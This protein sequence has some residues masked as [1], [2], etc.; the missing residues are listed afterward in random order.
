MDDFEKNSMQD[1][2]NLMQLAFQADIWQL[3]L[4]QSSVTSGK[5]IPE[6]ASVK[7]MAKQDPD[8]E[9][10]L[11]FKTEISRYEESSSPAV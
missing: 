9:Y 5:Y 3:G 4:Y 2:Q 11:F 7:M 8:T 10:E 6:L 1:R